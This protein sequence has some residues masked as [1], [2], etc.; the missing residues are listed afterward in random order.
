MIKLKTKHWLQKNT[1]ANEF[2]SHTKTCGENVGK[3]LLL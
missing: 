3:V 2:F 1:K